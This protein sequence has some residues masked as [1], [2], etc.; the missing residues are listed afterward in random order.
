MRMQ[1]I[2]VKF[3]VCVNRGFLP[4]RKLRKAE[5][6]AFHISCNKRMVNKHGKKVGPESIST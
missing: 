2:A 5:N 3:L 1:I 6:S 4:Y